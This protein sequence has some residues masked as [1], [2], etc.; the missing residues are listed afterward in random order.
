MR[1][2]VV[3]RKVMRVAVAFMTTGFAAAT[4]MIIPHSQGTEWVFVTLIAVSSGTLG[5]SFIGLG[6]MLVD[7]WLRKRKWRKQRKDRGEGVDIESQI[8]DVESTYHQGYHSY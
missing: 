4:L 2:L 1:L 5:E 3:A 8:S 7:H 6:V